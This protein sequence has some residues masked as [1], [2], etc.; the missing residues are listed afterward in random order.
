MSNQT[1]GYMALF[2]QALIPRENLSNFHIHHNA[3]C[4]KCDALHKEMIRVGAIIFCEK[5]IKEEFKSDDPVRL[6]RE[7]YLKWLHI[8][9]T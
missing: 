5:C 6:E 2:G 3:S 8:W 9:N 7:K 4:I 1:K